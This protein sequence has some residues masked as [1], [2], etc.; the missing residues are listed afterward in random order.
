MKQM[1]F[2]FKAVCVEYSIVSTTSSVAE[3]NAD[4]F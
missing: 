4:V 3:R 1:R 2:V